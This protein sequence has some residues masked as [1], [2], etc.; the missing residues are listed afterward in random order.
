[1]TAGLMMAPAVVL[2]GG[3]AIASAAGAAG[4]TVKLVELPLEIALSLATST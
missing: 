4:V 3:C 1:M 2:P